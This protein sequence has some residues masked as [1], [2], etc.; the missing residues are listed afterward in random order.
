MGIF[1]KIVAKFIVLVMIDNI[2][3]LPCTTFL[4]HMN[5][6]TDDMM[7]KMLTICGKSNG[8]HGPIYY[9]FELIQ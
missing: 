4:R 1:R 3:Q 5:N 9:M 6:D 8:R 2:K 7:Y